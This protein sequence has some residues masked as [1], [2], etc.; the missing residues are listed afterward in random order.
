L[1]LGGCTDPE[2]EPFRRALVEFE[3]GQRA[4]ENGAPELAA[5]HFAAASALD[6]N[7]A[8]L[9]AWHADALERAGQRDA[10]LLVLDEAQAKLPGERT[11]RYNRAALRMRKGDQVGAISDLRALYGAGLAEPEEVGRDPDFAAL[12]ANP[13]TASLAPA[14]RIEV[15]GVPEAGAVL[16]GEDW[17]VEVTFSAAVGVPCRFVDVPLSPAPLRLRRVVEDVLAVRNARSG[18]RVELHYEAVAVGAADLGPWSLQCGDLDALVGP[19]PV[20][21][22]AGGAG[23]QG[24]LTP[25]VGA[26][27]PSEWVGE[28]AGAGQAVTSVGL[29]V[30][31]AP[32]AELRPSDLG[33]ALEHRIAGQPD[34]RS[35]VLPPGATGWVV[36]GGAPVG[37]GGAP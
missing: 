16:L 23:G 14:P 30:T 26:L 28:A 11:L 1:G 31:A 5:R 9:P 36:S 35:W 37:P 29:V 27:L 21:V 3:A 20:D 25:T 6:P 18:R 15:A 7:S 10:A 4:L 2:L 33:I 12:A 22:R 34:W 19:W 32:S 8:A 17:T 13:A 24:D